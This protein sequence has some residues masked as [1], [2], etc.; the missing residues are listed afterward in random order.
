AEARPDSD[1][2]GQ[3]EPGLGCGLGLALGLATGAGLA[4]RVARERRQGW[5][6]GLTSGPDR[7]PSPLQSWSAKERSLPRHSSRVI[8]PSPFV[9]M[10][11]KRMGEGDGDGLG[12]GLAAESMTGTARTDTTTPTAMD[13]CISPPAGCAARRARSPPA[14]AAG[15]R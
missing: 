9:S 1:V 6:P 4:R 11:W 7:T 2:D 10:R 8:T 5:A 12:E 3:R 15:G 13:A 14:R